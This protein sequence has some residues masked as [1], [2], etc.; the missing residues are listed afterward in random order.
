MQYTHLF[1]ESSIMGKWTA[2]ALLT[3]PLAYI[4]G[5]LFL[6]D[7]K[8]GECLVYFNSVILEEKVYL[9]DLNLAELHLNIT[10]AMINLLVD[11]RAAKRRYLIANHGHD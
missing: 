2:A 1:C 8:L 3:T 9:A 7:N 4:V 10:S 11:Y 6:V 5:F